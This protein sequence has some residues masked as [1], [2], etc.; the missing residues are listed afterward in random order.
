MLHHVA[1]VLQVQQTWG[2]SHAVVTQ[3]PFSTAFN[4]GAGLD[5]FAAGRPGAAKPWTE[6]AADAVAPGDRDVGRIEGGIPDNSSS[7]SWY[8]LCCTD[9]LPCVRDPI[10]QEVSTTVCPEAS[11]WCESGLTNAACQHPQRPLSQ[12]SHLVRQC[13]ALLDDNVKTM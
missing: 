2:V 1:L 9:T 3:L 7:K 6:A 11:N 10:S 13:F 8:N 5:C 4:T 12:A